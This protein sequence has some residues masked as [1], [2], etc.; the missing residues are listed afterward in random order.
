MQVNSCVLVAAAIGRGVAM[1]FDNW[2][3]RFFKLPTSRRSREKRD[4]PATMESCEQRILLSGTGVFIDG[5]DALGDEISE[6]AQV[7]PGDLDGNGTIDAFTIKQSTPSRVWLNDG[8]GSFFDTGQRLGD[9]TRTSALA[10]ELA[11]LDGDQDLDD[12][13]TFIL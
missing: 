8:N 13:A 2:L 5:G 7:A 10:V 9:T 3:N 4:R 6:F 1:R 11:D 12:R